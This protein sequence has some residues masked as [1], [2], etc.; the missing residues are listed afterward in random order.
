MKVDLINLQLAFSTY[1]WQE[2]VYVH[3]AN[4]NQMKPNLRMFD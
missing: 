2:L 1:I 4:G 3:D